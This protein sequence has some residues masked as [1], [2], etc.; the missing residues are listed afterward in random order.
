MEVEPSQVD[1]AKGVFSA[2][3]SKKKMS[4]QQLAKVK[5][6]SVMG[7]GSVGA[8]FPNGCHITEVEIDPETGVAQVV[9]YNA[10]DDCGN[11]INH[12]IVEGQVH[13]AVV[14]G[15]G[16]ILREEVVYDRASGQLLTGSF[17]DY[18]MPR[19][20][21]IPG[22]RMEESPVPSAS[23][24]LGVKGV[25]ESGCTASMPAVANA[26]M[27]ALRPLGVKHLDMPMTP[28][29]VWRAIQSARATAQKH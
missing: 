19:A 15:V 25:G 9:S 3:G 28:A 21:L 10:V 29:R 14:Q 18:C 1:Y 11:V 22:I 27:D 17:M 7:E 23:N 6:F 4:L 16:Q 12:A 13:G 26:V 20:G 24:V 2:R 8:T 5:P